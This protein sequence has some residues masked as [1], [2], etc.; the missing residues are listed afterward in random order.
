MHVYNKIIYAIYFKTYRGF[1][2]F[3]VDNHLDPTND[4]MMLFMDMHARI[5]MGVREHMLFTIVRNE[6]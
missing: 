1:G 3:L 2:N 5:S 4:S 6:D